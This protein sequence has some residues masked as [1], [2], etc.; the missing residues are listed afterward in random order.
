MALVLKSS[1]QRPNKN[2]RFYGY[3]I[4]CLEPNRL[5][6]H[7]SHTKLLT[8]VMQHIKTRL[9]SLKKDAALLRYS[10]FGYVCMPYQTK[11]MLIST[12]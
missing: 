3:T 7:Y 12:Q 2:I 8:F 10:V 1:P 6:I 4:V 5:H 11:V 9:F